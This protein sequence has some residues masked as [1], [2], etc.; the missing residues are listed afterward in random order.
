[1]DVQ[2]STRAAPKLVHSGCVFHNPKE[3]KSGQIRWRCSHRCKGCNAKVYTCANRVV[4][5]DG[6]HN[7][8]HSPS[9]EH[10]VGPSAEFIQRSLSPLEDNLQESGQWSQKSAAALNAK[11]KDLASVKALPAVQNS[12]T[13]EVVQNENSE[14]TFI[15]LSQILEGQLALV[16]GIKQFHE[17]ALEIISVLRCVLSLSKGNKKTQK[18]VEEN[19]CRKLKKLWDKLWDMDDDLVSIVKRISGD[20][21]E[22]DEKSE[23]ED[24]DVDENDVTRHKPAFKFDWSRPYEGRQRVAKHDDV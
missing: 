19:V 15:I 21:E 12:S 13:I 9:A 14:K 1:M 5:V 22:S 7:H 24:E 6:E 8:S 11:E 3:L 16:T 18:S 20:E 2:Q 4:R 10:L 17:N 23:S